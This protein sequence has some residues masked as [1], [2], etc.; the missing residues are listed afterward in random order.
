MPQRKLHPLK[1]LFGGYVLVILTGA[2]LL[3]L[4]FMRTGP[5]HPL[6]ALFT[7]ASAVCVTGLI[8]KDTATFFTPWGKAVILLLIEIGGLGYMTFATILLFFLKGRGSLTLRMTMAESFPELTL[9]RIF[10]FAKRVLMLTVFFEGMGWL[11]LFLDFWRSGMAPIKALGTSLFVA[12]SA[13]CNAGFAPFSDSLISFRTHPLIMLT[14]V[15]LIVAGG[16]GFVVHEDLYFTWVRKTKR[17]LYLHSRV[18]LFATALLIG[19]GTLWLLGVDL[20]QVSG[21]NLVDRVTNALFMSVTPR[22]AGFN[23]ISIASLSTASVF[24][25][26][27]L[28]IIGGS[29]GGTAGGLKTTSITGLYLW[30]LAI[31]QGK[32][33]PHLWGYSLPREAL[34]RALAIA[35]LGWTTLLTAVFLLSITETHV[36]TQTGILPLIFE[37]ASAFG[38]VGLSFGSLIQPTVSL[39]HDFSAFGKG[40]IILTML[41]GRVG[42]LSFTA[43]LIQR[44]LEPISYIEG[45]FIVG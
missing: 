17:K 5:L 40:I 14:V 29:P 11:I 25:L 41:V 24:L 10:V 15:L 45:R 7:A 22:T 32:S 6:D 8:V 4:P 35:V 18:V 23:T 9:G 44:K 43:F 27:F 30:T 19:I 20:W 21:L 33:R 38:T 16:L 1:L 36:I 37:V 3:M 39:V 26:I 12:I 34:H 28:M 13:F 2:A 42:V 31:V